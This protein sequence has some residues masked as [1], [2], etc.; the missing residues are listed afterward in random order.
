MT[1]AEWICTNCNT[2]NRTFVKPGTT[3]LQD[4]CITCHKRHDVV[5]GE[6]P[7]RWAATAVK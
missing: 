5:P 2:T 3:R 6:R 1:S 7:I 4:R